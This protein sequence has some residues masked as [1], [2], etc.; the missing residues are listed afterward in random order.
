MSQVFFLVYAREKERERENSWSVSVCVCVCVD[1]CVQNRPGRL[2][3][4]CY[5]THARPGHS[6]ACCSSVQC[7]TASSFSLDAG[8]VYLYQR[9][10]VW[11]L[12]VH[13]TASSQ[14]CLAH[15]DS[16]SIEQQSDS[17][18]SGVKSEILLSVES[19][20]GCWALDL[21]TH[22]PNVTTTCVQRTIQCQVSTASL[23]C[24][25]KQSEIAWQKILSC[26]SEF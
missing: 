22:I 1:G 20:A 14:L 8:A 9:K 16:E 11:P 18:R 21:P 4:V 25:A 13:D 23:L 7:V 5:V 17:V 24:H 15:H 26:P 2:S 10:W 6:A 12:H 3:C 19:F